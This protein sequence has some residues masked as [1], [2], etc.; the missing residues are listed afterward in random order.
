MTLASKRF[1]F[2]DSNTRGH[3]ILAT[4]RDSA[5]RTGR[6]S[7][8]DRASEGGQESSP[9]AGLYSL[10]PK[11]IWESLR[12]Q[13]WS[14]RFVCV[15]LFFEYVRPQQ[16]YTRILGPP[17]ARIAII[18]ALAFFLIERRRIRFRA[19]EFLFATFAAIVVLSSFTAFDSSES[20]DKL[21]D[22]FNWVLIYLLIANTADSEER[23]L[24]FMLSFL[25]YSFKMSQFGTHSWASEGFKFRDW[26]TTGAPGFF[27]NSGEFGIQMCIFLPLIIAFTLALRSYWP[28]WLQWVGWAIAGTAVTGIVASSSRGAFIG[29]G[30]VVLWLLLKSQKKF[31]A[32]LITIAVVGLVYAITPDKQKDR[33]RV[34]GD[35]ETSISRTTAW[36][37]GMEMMHDFPVFGI[38]Y[39]NW[40]KY[41]IIRYGNNV[42]PHNVFI[43]AGAELG[44]TGLLAFFALIGCTFVINRRTRKLAGRGNYRGRFIFYMAQ[45]L[46][47]ALVGFLA[48]GFFV[49]T[50]ALYNAALNKFHADTV[51][52]QR[53]R[54]G[55]GRGGMRAPLRAVS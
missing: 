40:T 48:S 23:F 15:Y 47:G 45:G 12:R 11:A 41:R 22:F 38:G 39:S 32:L 20:Y 16:I 55:L 33:F 5:G 27:Q 2:M 4:A 30:A 44:Y 29:L 19:P 50:V 10:K 31:R 37:Q 28:R 36:N 53:G 14:F 26:G 42:L 49:M 35:D 34:A 7:G 6:Q 25:L 8:Y 21:T 54:S 1:R 52:S 46:D 24:I 51:S 3:A 18:L 13:P 9:L 17:Y 43:Q